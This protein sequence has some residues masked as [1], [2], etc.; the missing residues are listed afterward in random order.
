MDLTTNYLGLRLAHPLIVGASPIACDLALVERAV[1]SGAA[2]IVMH[3]LFEEQWLGEQRARERFHDVHAEAHAEASRYLPRP[4]D[5][6]QEPDEYL[7]HL[8]RI[9]RAVHVPVIA[10]LNGTSSGTWLSFAR[11]LQEAGASAL[12]LNLY[13]LTTDEKISSEVVERRAMHLVRSVRQSVD[14]PV[15]VKLS[16]FYTAL[17]HFASELVRVGADGFVLF[18]RFYQA[19][20]EVEALAVQRTL[21]L[22]DPSELLLRLR[23]LAVLSGRIDASLS[24]SGGVHEPVDVVKAIMAGAHSVQLVSTLLQHGPERIGVLLAGLREWMEQ[25]DYDS[26]DQMRGSM[27]L[28]RCPNPH[29]FERANYVHVLQSWNFERT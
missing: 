17:P 24:C 5:F 27:N 22:S 11:S 23:W 25:H 12:E 26:L 29:A 7:E 3:S 20:I 1:E 2:A 18:N 16:P 13:D 9:R 6:R 14:I 19:D 4:D 10:S 28:R 21:R 8:R 15:A